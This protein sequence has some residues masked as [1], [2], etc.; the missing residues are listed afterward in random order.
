ME[1]KKNNIRNVLEKRNKK[2][3]RKIKLRMILILLIG[4]SIIFLVL[5]LSK[6]EEK[7][8]NI[9]TS[10]NVEEENQVLEAVI[11]K[12]KERKIDDWRLVLVNSKYYFL[13]H[14]IFLS[15]YNNDMVLFV[16]KPIIFVTIKN[17]SILFFSMPSLSSKYPSTLR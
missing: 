15:N 5:I 12:K 1:N 11:S 6:K 3:R 14:R 16:S 8:Q 13:I 4:I 17:V 10:S 2:Y 9:E 7:E